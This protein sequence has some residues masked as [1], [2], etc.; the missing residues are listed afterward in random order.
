M[1]KRTTLLGALA[2]VLAGC[3][4][5]VPPPPP[6]SPAHL[7]PDQAPSA[8]P[9][10]KVVEHAP[11][12]PPPVAA[13]ATEKYTVVVHEVPVKE[14]LFALARDAAV[15][16]DVD[17]GIDGIVTLNA[18]DQTL[19]QILDRIARQVDMRYEIRDKNIL[20]MPDRP[21]FRSYTVDYVNL[22]R[23]TTGTI[24]VA[25]QIA[26]TGAGQI[27]EGGG[28]GG[29]GAGNN[30]STT[31]ITN[32]A[33][34]RFWLT[35]TRNIQALVGETASGS[36]QDLPVTEAVIPNP[37][38]GLINVRATAKQH[39][40]VQSFIDRVMANAHRQVLIEATVVEVALSDRYQQ[41]IDWRVINEGTG[42]DAFQLLTGS[43][44]PGLG[45]AA[46]PLAALGVANSFVLNFTDLDSGLGRIDV[47]VQLLRQFGDLQVLSSPRIM[48]L[49]NQPA[50]LKVVENVVYFEI[51]V[52]P[53]VATGNTQS[54]PAIETTAKTVPVGLVMT[55]TPQVNE[56]QSV[57][58]DM[59]PTISSITKSVPD[60]SPD[61]AVAGTTNLVP[62]I[63][64]REMESVLKVQ[65]GQIAVLGGLIQ[66]SVQQNS[67]RVPLLSDLPVL[68]DA[69]FKSHDN[70]YTRSELVIFLRPLVIGN[71]SIDADLSGYRPFLE[72]RVERKF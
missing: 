60:P 36:A 40:A 51:D 34:N 45:A 30:N 32:T 29:G 38:A 2:V 18:L 47:V 13:P 19:P 10:P 54:I 57:I 14:L 64:V 66:D 33:N 15:N 39:E 24:N 1:T 71:P 21:Y 3:S 28:G 65:N 55:V 70:L 46:P 37:E 4:G 22:S 41:G 53:G 12:L 44:A 25:T 63:Q 62:Q 43:L 6:S 50:V 58:L 23:D 72:E 35:L 11:F 68:G 31:A 49:N 48:A 8:G 59:R 20:V 42:F 16:V 69:F 27:G 61:L 26:T 17:P 7:R 52:E 56:N 5:L 67:N 9:I